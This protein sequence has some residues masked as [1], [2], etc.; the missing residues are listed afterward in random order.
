MGAVRHAVDGQPSTNGEA[1]GTA[2]ANQALI[3]ILY[4]TFTVF[5]INDARPPT[6]Y[7]HFLRAVGSALSLAVAAT[8]AWFVVHWR[9]EPL[10]ELERALLAIVMCLIV[11]HGIRTTSCSPL[12]RFRWAWLR[13]ISGRS[14]GALP[15]TVLTLAIVLTGFVLPMKAFEIPTHIAGKLLA[16]VLQGWSLPAYGAILSAAL[17]VELQR[18]ARE[19]GAVRVAAVGPP[20]AE[21]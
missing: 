10:L 17:M 9:R 7:P 18:L 21:M 5:D 3:N 14:L 2:Y 4:K 12:P 8:T 11:P 16:R 15:K 6:L 20:H 13:C 1:F 19:E